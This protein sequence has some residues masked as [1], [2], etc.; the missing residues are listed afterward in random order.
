MA[1]EGKTLEMGPL[2]ENPNMMHRGP[3]P[4]HR[5]QRGSSPHHNGLFEEGGP[6]GKLRCD[7]EYRT[8]RTSHSSWEVTSAETQGLESSQY[9]GT[10][11]AGEDIPE[12]GLG[13]A[14]VGG[15][16]GCQIFTQ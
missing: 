9:A 11:E 2:Q 7:P 3:L 14:K 10:R 8:R 4:E 1:R 15:L 13:R 5:D 12:E 6:L 16:S